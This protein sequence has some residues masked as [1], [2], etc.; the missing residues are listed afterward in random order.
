MSL[1]KLKQTSQHTAQII[2]RIPLESVVCDTDAF[3]QN[4]TTKEL[5]EIGYELED[6]PAPIIVECFN[7]RE[8]LYQ[9][10]FGLKY[11]IA[12]NLLN[13]ES[14]P[15]LVLQNQHRDSVKN[16]LDSSLFNWDQLDEIEC[17]RAYEWLNLACKYTVDEIAKMRKISRPVIGNQLR[18]L[19]LPLY[20]Q[21]L[22]QQG[23]LNKSICLLLLKLDHV[24]KQLTLAK[25]IV[26]GSYS[27]REAQALIQQSLPAPSTKR[28]LQ[29]SVHDN[30]LE[31]S[32]ESIE[33][34][35]KILAYLKNFS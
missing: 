25:T 10:L 33:L 9:I 23:R 15:A 19:K 35:D 29:I 6:R 7:E 21:Q 5:E 3:K 1:Y 26:D 30:T 22:L 8:G 13:L 2:Q 11:F 32:F 17:A 20:V 27:V 34:R 24:E 31:I 28:Q 4:W 14:I 16:F 12:A 18:L